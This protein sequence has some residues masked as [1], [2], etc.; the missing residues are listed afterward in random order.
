MTPLTK[1]SRTLQEELLRSIYSESDLV[2]VQYIE[3]HG[4]GTPAG[5]PTEAKSISNVIAKAKPSGSGMLRIGSV[6]SNI[7]HTESAAGV[8]GLIKVLLMMKHQTIVPSVFYSEENSSIDAEGLNLKIPSEPE[9]WDACGARVAGV[10]NFGFGGTNAHAI[11]KQHTQSDSKQK[12][13]G[14]RVKYFVISANSVKSLNLTVED[15]INHLE[16]SDRVD[17]D[18]LVYTSACRRSHLKH[19]YRKAMVVSS[20]DDLREKLKASLGKDISPSFSYPRLVF[21]FCGNGVT[22]QGMCQQLL[23]QE[24]VFRNKIQEISQLYQGL[25]PL[26]IL[27]TLACDFEFSNNDPQVVQPLLFSIQVGINTLLRQWGIKPDAMLGHSVGEIAAAHCSGLLSLEDAVKVIYFRSTLQSKVSGGKMLVISNMAVSDVTARLSRYSGYLCLAAFNSPLSCTV[28]GDADAVESLH[29]ELSTSANSQSLFLRLLDVPAAYHSHMMD[30]IL[31]DVRSRIGCLQIHGSDTAL[32]STVTG[33]EVHSV[34]VCTGEYWARNI[35]EPVAFEQAVRSA[36]KGKSNT[37]FVE[38]GPRRTL[39]RNIMET[40]GN[41]TPVF[42]SVQPEKDHET[43]K[44]LVSKLFEVGVNVNWNTYYRGHETVPLPI[45]KY[46]FDLSDKDVIVRAAQNNKGSH[47]PVLC[48]AG[49]GVNIFSCNLKSDSSFYLKEHKHNGIA[50]IPGA[51]YAE[52]GLA[53]YMAGAKPKVPLSSLQVSVSFHSP[54]VLAQN[55]PEMKV[56]LEHAE[57]ETNFTVISSSAVYASGTVVSKKGRLIEEQ[58]IDLNAISKRCKSVINFQE[59]YGFLSQGGFQYGDVFQNKGDVHYG[60]ELKEAFAVVRVP[61]ELHSQLHDYCIHP[62]LL[63]F[64]MQLLPVTVEHV[65]A[66]RPGFPSKIGS[67][68]VQEPLQDEMIVYLRATDVG[69]DHFEVCGCFADREGRVLVEAKHVII[70]YLGRESHVVEEYFYH[71]AFSVVTESIS[72]AASPRALVLCDNARIPKSLKQCLDSKS[73]Y[74]SFKHAKDVLCQGVAPISKKLKIPY[75]DKNFDEVLLLFGN[76]NLSTMA[77]E[78]VLQKLASCCEIIR[79]VVLELKRINFQNSIRAVTYHSSDITVDQVNPGFALVGMM[80]SFAAEMPD[81]RFQ[82]VDMV[83][84]S[85]KNIAALNEVLRSYPCSKYPE[86]VVK[87]G[88]VMKPAIVRTS[89]DVTDFSKSGFTLKSSEPCVFHTAD[90]HTMTQ[91]SAVHFQEEPDPLNDTFVEIQPSKMCVHSSDYFSVSSSHLKFGQT[92][93][94]NKHSSQK[95]KLLALDFCGTVTAVGKDVRKLKVGDHVASCYPVVAASRVRVPEHVCYNTTCFP[96]FR[97]APC[98]SYFVIAWEILHRGVLRTKHNLGIISPVPNCALVK[99][100]HLL[101]IFKSDWNVTVV[102]QDTLAAIGQVNTVVILPPCDKTLFAKICKI[103]GVQKILL[104]SETESLFAPD[105]YKIAKER[106]CVHTIRVADIL[107]TGSLSVETPHIKQWLKSLNISKELSFESVTFQGESSDSH[108][109]KQQSYF[110]S[111]KLALVVLD[112][113]GDHELSNISVTPTGRQFFKKRAVYMVAGGLSGLGFETVKF[114]SQR[115]GGY[116]VILSRRKPSPDVQQKIDNVETQCGNCIVALE[117][118][119]SVSESVAEVVSKIG[120]KFP[121]CPIR[122]VFHSAVVLHDGLIETLDQSLYEKVLRPKVKGVLNLHHATKHFNLDYFVCYS[123]MSAFL[124]N[125]SQTNYAAANS[126]LDMFCHYR[127]KLGLPAQSINWGALN[128]GLLLNKELFQRFLEA[129]GMMVLEVPEIHKSLEQCLL[130]NRPQQAI[131]RFHFRNIR[132]NVLSQN[133]ALTNRLS[134]LVY[135]AFLKSKVTETQSK[136][137]QAVSPREYILSLLSMTTGMD[138]SELK[139]DSP[140][141]LLGIDSMQAMTVQNLIFQDKGVNLPLVK[142]LDPNATLS[143]VIDLLSD[144]DQSEYSSNNKKE[145]IPEGDME[146]T[147]TRL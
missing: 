102:S 125:A 67:L 32:F 4:T 122:G 111:Q 93:Y 97:K 143:T 18:S 72:S 92:L 66:G 84:N 33:D 19:R 48:H 15:T 10:N 117:C 78:V 123:S 58:F 119:V 137:M 40:L 76:E 37:V 54:F 38:I 121:S 112:K 8:A 70:K 73:S 11:V 74:V 75:I 110:N 57:K 98:V 95:H 35:R 46:Q 25:S 124:G 118:D 5:D 63:D 80:R 13:D 91:I 85:S 140:L 22:Y 29:R 34:D 26:N 53:A 90:V 27:D 131:C 109:Q 134:E 60:E 71:N 23:H 139:D 144:G 103:P 9:K 86:L 83:S 129:K 6:K 56:Q 128:L 96:F 104:I 108:N 147:S 126:F 39:Q 62:V 127:R 65:F 49:S 30:P 130:L 135:E 133:V 79:Q 77:A 64:L 132:Y 88:L 101:T 44:L 59:F 82:L 12:R 52:L 41:D 7:G 113:D 100:L 87:D 28:S 16:V 43:V 36:T 94:W 2:R 116:V 142:L 45:P 146:D 68:T 120:Q 3:A 136:Q 55:S 141:S 61:E 51:F 20:V 42:A 21:V 105:A 81:L 14:K 50:I 145:A 69:E 89:A 47:H 17:L 31:E 24:P 106:I 1:P 114:I 138:R 115:G 99:V 107:Q